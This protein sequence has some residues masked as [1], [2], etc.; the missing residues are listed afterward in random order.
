MTEKTFSQTFEAPNG[1]SLS[2]TQGTLTIKGPKGEVS[3]MMK[4]PQVAVKIE[5]NKISFTNIRGKTTKREKKQIYAYLAHTENMAK[6]VQEPYVY[7]VKVCA[8]HFPINVA[9]SGKTFSVKNFLGEKVPRVIT[10]KDNVKVEIAG[11]IITITS[12]D[13]ERAG[14]TAAD[15]EQLTRV[16]NRDLRIFQDGLYIIE[17]CGE[18]VE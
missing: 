11:E 16:T 4:S 8:G 10:L 15:L 12:C 9:L 14:Q 2:Y 3:K 7:K 5:G 1:V 18:K 13:V 17:K 6:G